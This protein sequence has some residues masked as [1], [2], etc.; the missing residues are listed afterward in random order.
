MIIDL[1][2][3]RAT[4]IPR[5]GGKG[6][7]LGELIAAGLPVPGGFCV[8]ATPPSPASS[9][10]SWA[11]WERTP[12]WRRSASA[13]RPRSNHAHRRRRAPERGRDDGAGG[14]SFM[15]GMRRAAPATM[16]DTGSTLRPCA[17]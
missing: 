7:N 8:T 10:P 2:A 5:V 15:T 6:A 16:S 3:V 11:W 9:R 4:D 1:E 12:S 17:W 14:A 13:G